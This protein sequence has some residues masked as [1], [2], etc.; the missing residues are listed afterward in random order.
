MLLRI[1]PRKAKFGFYLAAPSHPDIMMQY[2][3]LGEILSHYP[4]QYSLDFRTSNG[5]R[6]DILY[7]NDIELN[8]EL[9]EAFLQGQ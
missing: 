8:T 2:G 4:G 3:F 1:K 7:T 9:A 5:Q 6:R